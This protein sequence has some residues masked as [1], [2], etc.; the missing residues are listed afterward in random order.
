MTK[1]APAN[2]AS[3]SSPSNSGIAVDRRRH[4]NGDQQRLIKKVLDQARRSDP[5]LEAH[6]D[7]NQTNEP[8][9][10]KSIENMRGHERDDIIFSI[11][12]GQDKT[13]R[14]TAQMPSPT[15]KAATAALTSSSHARRELLVFATLRPEPPAS[16]SVIG[17]KADQAR[18]IGGAES[19][20]KRPF[21]DR[22]PGAAWAR[23]SAYAVSSMMASRFERA[24]TGVA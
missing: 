14:I 5:S 4:F 21:A 16:T 13:G 24:F 2:P 11:A 10:V 17:A 15:T 7:R 23:Y 20:P 6:F 22:L 3:G 19:D 1:A 18:V 9:L 12:V 8:I